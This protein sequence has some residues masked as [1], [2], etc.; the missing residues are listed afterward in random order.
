MAE[1]RVP[2]FDKEGTPLAEFFDGGGVR[3]AEP[4]F[5]PSIPD[6]RVAPW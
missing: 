4:F 3:R 2:P 5:L 6:Q 1:I